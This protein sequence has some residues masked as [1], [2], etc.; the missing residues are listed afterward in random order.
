MV[1]VKIRDTKTIISNIKNLVV[2]KG[3]IYALCMILFEDFHVIPEKLHEI[4]N[5]FRLSIKEVSLLLGFLIQNK[6][7]FSTSN[8]PQ[9]L[10]KLKQKT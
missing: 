4:D 9:D 3:F 6:I 2:Q 1:E 10:I 5:R 8:T 7:D